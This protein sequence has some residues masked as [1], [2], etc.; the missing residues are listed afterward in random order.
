MLLPGIGTHDPPSPPLGGRARGPHSADRPDG[1]AVPRPPG[2]AGRAGRVT[3]AVGREPPA[4]HR[5]PGRAKCATL[6]GEGDH[7]PDRDRAAAPGRDGRRRRA[8][9][10]RARAIRCCGPR[11]ARAAVRRPR[12]RR[13]PGGRRDRGG[14]GRPRR[15][16][17]VHP[18]AARGPGHVLGGAGLQRDL[19]GRERHRA[20]HRARD[21]P[22]DL[23]RRRQLRRRRDH[24]AAAGRGRQH[25]AVPVRAAGRRGSELFGGPRSARG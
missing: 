3:L 9:P 19:R 24:R 20:R 11:R 6:C 4:C 15:G 23:R 25:P 21:R 12:P 18:P 8:L 10:D 14:D 17:P 13:G 2:Q 16:H 1:P 7:E 22:H 5:T